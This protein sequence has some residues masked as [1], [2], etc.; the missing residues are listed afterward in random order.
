LY[1]PQELLPIQ[2][3]LPFQ[4]LDREAALHYLSFIAEA[5]GR[6]M[7]R[8]AIEQAADEAQHGDQGHPSDYSPRKPNSKRPIDLRQ[9]IHQLHFASSISSKAQPSSMQHTA[10][11]DGRSSIIKPMAQPEL[12]DLARLQ[13]LSRGLSSLSFAY[14]ELSR[15]FVRQSAGDEPSSASLPPLPSSSAQ[16][17]SDQLNGGTSIGGSGSTGAPASSSD[18][19]LVPPSLRVLRA[20][21]NQKACPV[22]LPLEGREDVLLQAAQESALACISSAF[23][24]DESIRTAQCLTYDL[25][26]SYAED[27]HTQA[28]HLR[29]MLEPLL[30]PGLPLPP[31]RPST[32]PL[33]LSL[34]EGKLPIAPDKFWTDYAPYVRLMVRIEDFEE[35]MRQYAQQQQEQDSSLPMGS[36]GGGGSR[37]LRT[38][39]RL[40]RAAAQAGS[41]GGERIIALDKEGL[42]AARKSASGFMQLLWGAPA[43]AAPA[44][45]PA[46]ALA[47]AAGSSTNGEQNDGGGERSLAA[48]LGLVAVQLPQVGTLPM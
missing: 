46:P 5:E 3:V 30:V 25:D 2:Q 42:E 21:E 16:G 18:E 12:A 32:R 7:T 6:P 43:P 44:G 47:P 29:C 33:S 17:S 9:A 38:S 41:A 23:S 45:A 28:E 14:A 24:D 35:V 22:A 48:E 13:H 26:H 27:L 36:G 10:E 15:P 40:S 31:P 4:Q 1:I 20:Q 39:T 37:S 11:T 8:E 19:L 34:L